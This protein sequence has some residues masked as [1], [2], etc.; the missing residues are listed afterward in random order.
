MELNDNQIQAFKKICFIYG[1]NGNKCTFLNHK[2]AQGF[3]V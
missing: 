1:N 2:L 3:F